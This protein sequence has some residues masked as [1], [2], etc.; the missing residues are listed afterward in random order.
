MEYLIW[1]TSQEEAEKAGELLEMFPVA[2]FPD[3]IEREFKSRMGRAGRGR[4]WVAGEIPIKE[5]YWDEKKPAA[6]L[7]S[8][9]AG[10]VI[11]EEDKVFVFDT[12]GFLT[13]LKLNFI[14]Q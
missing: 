4:L 3:Y 10:I 13:D 6:R 5:I 14:N 7:A 9:R 8:A 11:R 1:W 12:P 2:D